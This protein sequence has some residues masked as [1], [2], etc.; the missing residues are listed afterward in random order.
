MAKLTAELVGR[1]VQLGYSQPNTE[2]ITKCLVEQAHTNKVSFISLSDLIEILR[3]DPLI[4]D[5]DEDWEDDL[6][7]NDDLEFPSKISIKNQKNHLMT[8]ELLKESLEQSALSGNALAH[9][10]LAEVSRC[11]RP[12]HYLFDEARKGRILNQTE[13]G[14]VDGYENKLAQFN[15]FKDHL[16]Q[17][18]L[19]GI[20]EA[21]CEYVSSFSDE[22]QLDMNEVGESAIQAQIISKH[23]HP[24]REME[25]LREAAENGSLKAMKSLAN[26]GDLWAIEK[27]AETGDIDAIWDLAQMEMQFDLV[28]AWSWIY[29]AQKLG[30]DF[31][32]S[33]MRAYHDGDE[34]DG[35]DY[36]DDF[37]GSM[38]V[39]GDEGMDLTPL[40][41]KQDHQAHELAQA[42][43]KKIR[44]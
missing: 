31:T 6:E 41:P 37:G 24:Q 2:A 25:A 23:A 34:H 5:E 4:E 19:G 11:R 27:M 43:F 38:Y 36:D 21:A 42:F 40:E 3:H 9:F 1:A 7:G 44:L 13:Q 20:Y 16:R 26:K 22:H 15:K 12:S 18:A 29:V 10:A 35:Q 28:K 33:D 39:A 32:E 30:T 17:A 8:S 14:W